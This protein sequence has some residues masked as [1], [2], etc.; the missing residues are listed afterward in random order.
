MKMEAME[1]QC[2]MIEAEKSVLEGQ[3]NETMTHY[4]EL[5]DEMSRLRRELNSRKQEIRDIH[6]SRDEA[7]RRA[8][9]FAENNRTL[10]EQ[11]EENRAAVESFEVGALHM[12]KIVS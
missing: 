8:E 4:T 5:H 1:R 11:L 6:S 9:R 3:L 2:K 10:L 12:Q 7:I